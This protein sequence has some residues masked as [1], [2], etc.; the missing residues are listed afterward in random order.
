M[1]KRLRPALAALFAMARRAF[2]KPI[3]QLSD[4]RKERQSLTDRQ[5]MLLKQSLMA[6]RSEFALVSPET[7]TAAQEQ[8]R[9]AR[10]AQSRTPTTQR[11]A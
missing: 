7:T 1:V 5:L 4:T 3:A 6:G 2:S 11:G 9:Q 10:D 8:E